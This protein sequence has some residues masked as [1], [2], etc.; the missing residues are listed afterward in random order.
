V[1]LADISLHGC[2]IS[3]RFALRLRRSRF[4]LG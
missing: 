2:G 1:M 3:G 4:K